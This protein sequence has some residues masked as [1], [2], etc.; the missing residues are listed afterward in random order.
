MRK[1]IF[2]FI[3]LLFSVFLYAQNNFFWDKEE[4]FSTGN[5]GKIEVFRNNNLL[6]TI[7]SETININEAD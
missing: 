5:I 6:G 7:F 3:F 2:I 4:V 1:S